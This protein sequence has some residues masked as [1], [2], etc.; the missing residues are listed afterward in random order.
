MLFIISLLN[1]LFNLWQTYFDVFDGLDPVALDFS[2]MGKGQAWVNGHHIGRFW[3]LPSSQD[4]CERSCDYRGKYDSSKCTTNCGKPTQVR[5][6]VC[7][8]IGGT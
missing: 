3:T 1:L 7:S 2:S 8:L 6:A 4:G 5:Y